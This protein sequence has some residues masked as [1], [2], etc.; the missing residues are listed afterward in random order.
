MLLLLDRQGSASCR[1]Q[2]EDVG[3]AA[4]RTPPWRVSAVAVPSLLLIGG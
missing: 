3:G 4:P 1:L 2:S